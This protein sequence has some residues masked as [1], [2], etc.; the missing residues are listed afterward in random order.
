[1]GLRHLRCFVVLAEEL[2]FTRAAERLHIKQ[3]PFS[4]SIKELEEDLEFFF[5]RGRY[6]KRDFLGGSYVL[7][8]HFLNLSIG[9]ALD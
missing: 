6:G 2:P 3:A 7:S 5:F 9:A 8:F 1:M 4:R